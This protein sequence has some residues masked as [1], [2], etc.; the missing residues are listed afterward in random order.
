MLDEYA[1]KRSQTRAATINRAIY[2]MIKGDGPAAG[3]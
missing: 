3:D 1:A 2:Q